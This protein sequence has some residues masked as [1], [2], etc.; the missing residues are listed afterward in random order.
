ME[1]IIPVQTYSVINNNADINKIL[2]KLAN[3]ALSE[4]SDVKFSK[5]TFDKHKDS[6]LAQESHLKKGDTFEI[7][8]NTLTYDLDDRSL[9]MISNSLCNGVIYNYYLEKNSLVS[10]CLQKFI[11]ALFHRI[12]KVSKNKESALGIIRN[13]LHIYWIEED[14][15]IYNFSLF[16]RP[17]SNAPDHCTFYFIKRKNV[18]YEALIETV[19]H[20][21]EDL[22]RVFSYFRRNKE[23]D[24]L[25]IIDQFTLEE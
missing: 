15:Y 6:A 22:K 20:M 14:T 3:I 8:T 11:L 24:I 19:P 25:E 5:R 4:N 21:V 2:I 7:M 1:G 17:L 9:N 13:T 16:N 10:I 12:E 23:L 18:L